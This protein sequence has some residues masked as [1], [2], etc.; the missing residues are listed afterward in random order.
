MLTALRVENAKPR[1]KPCKLSDSNGLHLLVKPPGSKLWRL[2]Y[3]FAGKK[4]MLSLGSFPEVSLA[5]ARE[6]CDAARKLV[7]EGK[8]PSQ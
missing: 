1:D 4:N 7:A 8:D 5:T 3:Y 2:R 6:K